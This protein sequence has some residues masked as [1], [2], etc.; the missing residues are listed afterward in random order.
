M[1]PLSL[2]YTYIHTYIHT[3]IYSIYIHTYKAHIYIIHACTTQLQGNTGFYS[4]K[5]NPRTIRTWDLTYRACSLTPLYDDQT[6]FW[7][8]LRSNLDPIA[9]P[10]PSCPSSNTPPSTSSLSPLPSSSLSS[11][12]SL[13]IPQVNNSVVSCPLDSCVFSA[14]CLRS[15][16]T[17]Y[18]LKVTTYLFIEFTFMVYVC[19]Y[20]CTH[21]TELYFSMFALMY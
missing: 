17:F 21:H 9:N 10:L 11:S 4:V 12:W 15:G 16:E 19:M 3:Y 6:M 5:S 20:A 1:D 13:S 8:I 18:N 2:K 14:G 7:L